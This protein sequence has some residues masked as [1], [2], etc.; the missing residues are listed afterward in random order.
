M[1]QVYSTILSLH[2]E[3]KD[4]YQV[5]SL[6][7]S[8]L[9]RDSFWKERQEREGL[10]FI[11]VEGLHPL[12]TYYLTR[13][14]AK[15]E[16]VLSCHLSELPFFPSFASGEEY[17][18]RAIKFRREQIHANM[19]PALVL[20]CSYQTQGGG[21]VYNYTSVKKIIDNLISYMERD[22]GVIDPEHPSLNVSVKLYRTESDRTESDRTEF[23]NYCFYLYMDLV[24][25]EGNK[26]DIPVESTLISVEQ[27]LSFYLSSV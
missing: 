25:E 19:N 6:F 15:K 26:I 9:S 10:P 4:C 24:D 2:E 27:A 1:L 8:I 11:N 13:E 18:A 16:V 14:F 21:K 5:C 3:P 22:L 7:A 20:M 17:Y 23:A 12:R